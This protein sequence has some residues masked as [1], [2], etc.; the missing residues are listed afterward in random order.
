[1]AFDRRRCWV[2]TRGVSGVA[3]PLFLGVP[4]FAQQPRRHGGRGDGRPL[5]PGGGRG[6]GSAITRQTLACAV[7]RS[8]GTERF[9]GHPGWPPLSPA[10]STD[11]VGSGSTGEERAVGR[12]AQEREW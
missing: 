3:A 7:S 10:E 4:A 11:P 8:L 12:G 6:P 5:A 1:M 9:L 2:W